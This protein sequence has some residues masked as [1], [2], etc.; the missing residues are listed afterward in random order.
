MVPVSCGGWTG[1]FCSGSW[2]PVFVAQSSSSPHLAP[3]YLPG[4]E[5]SKL[6]I[7]AQLLEPAVKEWLSPLAGVGITQAADSSL[8]GLKF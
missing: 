4:I 2:T 8:P 7:G 5:D 6:G 1:R 3:N